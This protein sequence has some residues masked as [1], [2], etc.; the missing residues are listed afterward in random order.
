MHDTFIHENSG[1]TPGLPTSP[2]NRATV[3]LVC[4]SLAAI[5]LAVFG[6]TARFDFVNFDDGTFIYKAAGVTNGITASGLARAF[7]H[8]S[9]ANWDPLTTI[10][11]MLDCRVYGLNAGG[12]HLTNVLL[13]AASVI[14]LFLLLR[15]LTS[16]L[17][18]SA[19]VAAV[20]AVH[21]LRVESVAWV[22]ERKD[23]LSG[24]FFMLTLGAYA[25][26]VDGPP[27][28]S[29]YLVVVICFVLGLMSK[30]ML[31]TLPLVLL[32]LD[33]WPLGRIDALTREGR[34]AWAALRSRVV[35]EKVPLL[36]LSAGACIVAMLTQRQAG[37][38]HS[39]GELP[40]SLRIG[41]AVVSL[42]TYVRQMFWPTGLAVMYPFPAHGVEAGQLVPAIVFTAAVFVAVLYLRRTRPYLLAGW[43]WYCVM[44]LPVIGL[45]QVGR[46]AHADRYTYL[47]QIGLYV[48]LT[49][50]AGS[51]G[52]GW[53]HRRAVYGAVAGLIIAELAVGAFN[54]TAY[55][56]DSE[57]LWRRDLACVPDNVVARNNLGL[58]MVYSGRV[59]EAM[60]EF[61]QAIKIQPDNAEAYNNLGSALANRGWMDEA[62]GAFEQ[63]LKLQPDYPQARENLTRALGQKEP[64]AK[65]YDLGTE[66]CQQGRIDEAIAQFQNALAILPGFEKAR[67]ALELIAWDLATSPDD[68]K[69]NGARALQLAQQLSNTST[70]PGG[71][72]GLMATLAAAYAE[73]G[74]F[75]DAAAAAA[76]AQQIAMAQTN[77]PLVD[78]LQQQLDVYQSGRPFRDVSPTNAP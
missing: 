11:H 53:R 61:Q 39:L 77:A 40:I 4:I 69:R 49:W 6:R 28:L 70:P 42:A 9:S 60:A 65:A 58:V 71:D 57:A 31:V 18:S 29:R 50:L 45:V 78:A 21:P 72:P 30:V 66:L 59:A 46:Q 73:T 36:A 67:L 43:L 23:V 48:A 5:T 75:A 25:R 26:Y 7:T 1:V 52:A 74:R 38:I 14:L 32:L 17:W 24:L 44:L 62:V 20:F 2:D 63:A 33:Y 22:S 54:Q 37:A 10:S 27:K 12:H 15:K 35:L 13:H 56:R 68:T 41:N 64:L 47:P 3:R 19:F 8:G 55:W 76:R 34:G 51:F 16:E